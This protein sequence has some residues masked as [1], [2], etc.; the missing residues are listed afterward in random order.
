MTMSERLPRSGLK[1]LWFNSWRMLW[2]DWR[3]G[4]LTILAIGLVIAVTSIT[5][6]GFFTDRIERGLKE[7]SAE[8]IG[9][10]LVISSS[11]QDVTDYIEAARENNFLVATTTTFR[12]VVLHAERLQLAEVKAVSEAY[13]LRGVLRVSDTPFGDDEATTNIPAAGDV[14][15]EARL[16]QQLDAGV[17]DRVN[18]GNSTFTIRKV[19]RYEPDRAGDMFSVAPRVMMNRADLDATGLITTGALSSFRVLIA[20]ERE[21]IDSYSQAIEASLKKGE[22]IL[23][24]EE[25][26]PELNTALERAQQFLG[27][28]AL[29]SVLLAGVAVATVAYRFT[30]RHLDTGAMMRCLGASQQVII[31][32]F[33]LEMLWLSLLASSVGCLLGLLTQFVITELLDQLVLAHLPPPSFKALLLGYATGIVMLTGFAIPPLLSLKRVPPLRVLRKDVPVTPVSGWII[34]LSVIACMALLLYWQVGDIK[35]VATVLGGIMATLAVLAAAAYL[36]ILVL[37]RLRGRVG[38]AWRFGLANIARRPFS[39]VIQIVAFGL[40]IMVML[41]LSTVRS[42]LLDDWQRSLPASAPNHFVINVQP[43]QVDG[44]TAYFKQRGVSNTQ[45]YPMVRARLVE[46]NGE[47][48]RMSDYQTERARHMI[49]REFNLSWAEHMQVDNTL[50]A[51]RW[52]SRA[53]YGTPMLSL[54]ARL[55]QT[56]HLGMNDVLGFDVNGSIIEFRIT[57][58]R[59]VDWDT[60]NINFFTVVPPG[61]LEDKPANWLTSVYLDNEQRRQLGELVRQYPNITLIDV[62]A[63]MQRVRG[64]MDRVSLAVEF[65]FLFTIL[66]GLAVLYAAI[67]ANQDE[68]RFENAVLRTLGARRQTLLL[69]L[70]AEFTTL[71]ALSGLL[72]GLS[73]TTLA[74]VLADTIFNFDY[75]FDIT[76]ALTGILSGIMIVAIAGLLGTRS[77]LAHPPVRTLREGTA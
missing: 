34:Y 40:G 51:G 36:L 60:F 59:T 70:I 5:A 47:P 52:W 33:T 57:S 1:F 53:D 76:V 69:G 26:R 65:I 77:V 41:L 37:N 31:R 23:T 15:V 32:L 12:S 4:E 28:A 46:I 75:Q 13:P 27:L 43:D 21:R 61:V 62:D 20:G 66:A 30:S 55:A 63:I 73:A 67:Q 44:I 9:A 35:L 39:S 3:G 68:R 6:V 8:L 22:Q 64:I 25:G 29:I 72:A 45:L 42:D 74:W 14:W 10:D 19:L 17:G 54:E 38:V 2:R 48:V 7:Q 11:R 18:L 50:V 49:T 56:L 24:V 16:L 71:G 58:L